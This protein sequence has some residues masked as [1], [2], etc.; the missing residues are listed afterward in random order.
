MSVAQIQNLC[1][2]RGPF[3]RARSFRWKNGDRLTRA[4]F[5]RRYAAMPSTKAEIDRGIV[6]YGI[7]GSVAS[8][9]RPDREVDDLVGLLR[10][11][12]AGAL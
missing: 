7:T 4:E 12:N 10:R 2:R 1:R 9:W 6:I 11:E 3:P 5:E 8:T